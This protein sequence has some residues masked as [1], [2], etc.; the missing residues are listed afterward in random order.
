MRHLPPQDQCFGF[1]HLPHQGCH[2]VV[3]QAAQSHDTLMAVDDHIAAWRVALGNHDDRL[4]LAML[5]Q[6]LPQLTLPLATVGAQ[7]GVARLQLMP[8]QIHNES[9]VKTHVSLLGQG[10]S[11]KLPR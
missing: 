4:L 9:S 7:R 8:F 1:L 2:G 6:A 11:L 5:F 10:P 3:A